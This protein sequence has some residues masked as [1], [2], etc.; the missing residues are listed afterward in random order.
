MRKRTSAARMMFHNFDADL[1][2]RWRFFQLVLA[3]PLQGLAAVV[4][5]DQ[6]PKKYLAIFLGVN[7]V[8]QQCVGYHLS[9]KLLV[10]AQIPRC[11]TSR[12]SWFHFQTLSTKERKNIYINAYMIN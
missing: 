11:E 5:V 1:T 10:S 7:V 12:C 8:F 6:S 2:W 9:S 3:F 4:D